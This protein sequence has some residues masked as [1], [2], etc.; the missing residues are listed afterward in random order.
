MGLGSLLDVP[1]AEA[2]ELALELRKKVRNGIDVI[3][4]RKASKSKPAQKVKT[5]EECWTEY[6]A[7]NEKKWKKCYHSGESLEK[8]SH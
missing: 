2:R 8:C 1:L 6:I 3:E 5:F 4:E 7:A